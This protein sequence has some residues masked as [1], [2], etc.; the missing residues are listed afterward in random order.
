MVFCYWH[1]IERSLIRHNL[2][3]V[4]W[5]YLREHRFGEV[6]IAGGFKLPG[7]SF[8]KPDVSFITGAQIAGSDPEAISRARG[9]CR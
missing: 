3:D 4:L 5:P 6:Y 7:E 1:G 9:A 8:L 2:H